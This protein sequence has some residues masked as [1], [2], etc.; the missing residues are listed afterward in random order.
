MTHRQLKYTLNVNFMG[1][2]IYE[3]I[4]DINFFKLQICIIFMKCIYINY[5]MINIDN[6]IK[7]FI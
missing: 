3:I 7:H 5:I 4:T 6:Y 2:F 1:K